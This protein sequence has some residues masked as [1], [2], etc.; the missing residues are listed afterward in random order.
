VLEDPRPPAN[1]RF[2][3]S[4]RIL[5][6][7]RI[8]EL[9]GALSFRHGLWELAAYNAGDV[10]DRFRGVIFETHRTPYARHRS[11]NE[12]DQPL[13]EQGES[14]RRVLRGEREDQ[15]I[16]NLL[17]LPVFLGLSSEGPADILAN[18]PDHAD[19]YL[20]RCD[21]TCKKTARHEPKSV[22]GLT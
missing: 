11:V 19:P 6:V 20:R 12:A 18:R 14:L 2:T 17:E 21:L 7:Q 10:G 13:L 8:I 22:L 16:G 1:L 4:A 5:L 3:R 15:A 9:F